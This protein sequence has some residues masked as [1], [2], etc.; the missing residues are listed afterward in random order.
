MADA[1]SVGDE[2]GVVSTV[3][4]AGA[5]VAV[6]TAITGVSVGEGVADGVSVGVAVG[7][8][9]GARVNVEEGSGTAVAS[10]VG[11]LD[12]DATGAR[13]HPAASSVKLASNKS[14]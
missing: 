11:K 14:V 1:D 8:S 10:R 9:V 7:V 6:D 13:I 2:N 3:T 12:E 4:V 5:V